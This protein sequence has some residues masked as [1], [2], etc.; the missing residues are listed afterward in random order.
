LAAAA[1]VVGEGISLVVL[2]VGLLALTF[3]GSGATDFRE[4]LAGCDSA[5]RIEG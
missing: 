3:A 4:S 2:C 1:P 5:A